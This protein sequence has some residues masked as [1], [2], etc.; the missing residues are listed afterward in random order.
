MNRLFTREDDGKCYVDDNLF[1]YS[2][3][4][5]VEE[6]EKVRELAFEYATRYEELLEYINNRYSKSKDYMVKVEFSRILDR[7]VD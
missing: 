7:F 6:N 4:S 5:E 2:E 3:Y 1:K